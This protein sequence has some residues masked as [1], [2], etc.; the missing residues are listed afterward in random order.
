MRGPDLPLLTQNLVKKY[1]SDD[2]TGAV[3]C[4][5][6]AEAPEVQNAATFRILADLTEELKS[7]CIGVFSKTDLSLSRDHGCVKVQASIRMCET[8][9]FTAA[10]TLILL[11]R[12]LQQVINPSSDP[13][14]QLIADT[15]RAGCVA[16]ANQSTNQFNFSEQLRHESDFFL[17]RSGMRAFLSIPSPQ[18]HPLLSP[19]VESRVTFNELGLSCLCLPALIS[20]IDVIIRYFISTSFLFTLCI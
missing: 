5:I 11:Q 3:I 14:F 19:D 6:N 17:H 9:Y 10:L 4:V 12:W 2:R 16:V 18:S 13:T 1:L 8:L 20:K 15:F 7:N